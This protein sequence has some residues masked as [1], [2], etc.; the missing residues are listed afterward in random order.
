MGK[1][2]AIIIGVIIWPPS[3]ALLGGVSGLGTGVSGWEAAAA[4]APTAFITLPAIVDAAKRE[5]IDRLIWNL[6]LAPL[7]CILG[8]VVAFVIRHVLYGNAYFERGVMIS[9]SMAIALFAFVG[10]ALYMTPNRDE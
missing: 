10:L 8:F 3:C 1:V 7:L 4:F 6:A 5:Q 9:H 2:F